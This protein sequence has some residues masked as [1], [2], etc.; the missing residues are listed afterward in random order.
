MSDVRD[1]AERLS[2]AGEWIESRLQEAGTR[3]LGEPGLVR[4]RPWSTQ[5]RVPTP[6]GPAWF[7]ANAPAFAF[8]PPLHG[9]LADLLP[10]DVDTPLGV[11]ADRGWLLTRDRGPTLG[12]V[13]EASATDWQQILALMARM[14]MALTSL[15]SQVLATGLPDRRPEHLLARFDATVEAVAALP[16]GHPAQL[17]ADETAALLRARP[18]VA[19]AAG[20][21]SACALPVTLQHADLHPYNVFATADGLRLF[22]FGDAQWAV[23]PEVLFIP[24]EVIGSTDP[25]GG[26]WPQALEGYRSA[27]AAAEETLTTAG[28][29]DLMPQVAL[30][31]A[32]NRCGT[33]L[34][35][36]TE[37]TPDELAEWGEGPRRSLLAVL[38]A[39]R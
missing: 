16:G 19:Q 12:A 38:E 15:E 11:D 23:A 18:R 8:E 25:G 24:H 30:S 1:R 39:D 21:L 6:S 13:R 34:D 22:D 32:V 9:L 3:S 10:D 28:L 27:W 26:I 2:G 33:W 29:D 7:K 17:A 36:L 35:A 4:D 37:A 20:W 14:Q 31:A 5:L